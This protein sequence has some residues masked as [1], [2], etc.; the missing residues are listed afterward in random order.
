MSDQPAPESTLPYPPVHKDKK[1][2]AL[3][4]WSVHFPKC[5]QLHP[6]LTNPTGMARSPLMIQTIV[7]HGATTQKKKKKDD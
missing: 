4:D 1:F 2:I 5:H 6:I 7:S 3:S